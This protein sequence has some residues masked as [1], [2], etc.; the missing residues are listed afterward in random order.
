[1]GFVI[2]G[3][4][5]GSILVHALL[6]EPDLFHFSIALFLVI[7]IVGKSAVHLGGSELREILKDVFS[8]QPTTV[9]D[10]HGTNRETSPLNDRASA[11]YTP[12]PLDIG[13]RSYSLT[14]WHAILFLL[15]LSSHRACSTK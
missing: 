13:M 11:A 9:V 2:V 7:K 15:I 10:H 14:Y 6:L 4:L 1:M 8:R 5:E 12:L 3:K